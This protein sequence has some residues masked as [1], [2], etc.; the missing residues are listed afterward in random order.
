MEIMGPKTENGLKAVLGGGGG[1]KHIC[2]SPPGKFTH[3][4]GL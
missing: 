1:R 2:I 4:H 3:H